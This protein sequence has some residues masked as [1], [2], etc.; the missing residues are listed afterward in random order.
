M[1]FQEFSGL[2]QDLATALRWHSLTPGLLSRMH[3]IIG[4]GEFAIP[5]DE[6]LTIVGTAMGEPGTVPAS[7]I[8]ALKAAKERRI[9][10]RINPAFSGNIKPFDKMTG[11]EQAS[12][13][14]AIAAAKEKYIA[15]M[16]EAR[17]A[18]KLPKS[19]VPGFSSMADLVPEAVR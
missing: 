12:Y 9:R 1:D 7:V 15:P 8:Q 11:P 6:V 19:Q 18:G 10:S 13:L 2:M 17:A 14:A 3:E 5:E 4:F 16:L